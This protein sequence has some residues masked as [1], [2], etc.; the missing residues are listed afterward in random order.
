M[1]GCGHLNPSHRGVPRGPAEGV[2]AGFQPA[3]A[4]HRSCCSGHPR[5][6]AGEKRGATPGLRSSEVGWPSLAKTQLQPVFGNTMCCRNRGSSAFFMFLFFFFFP[7]LNSGVIPGINLALACIIST[8]FIM[9]FFCAEQ[10]D[11][12]L[13]V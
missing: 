2:G 10:L 3:L 9:G 6:A 8:V 13:V 1:L 4:V 5:G 7:S 11:F 12:C